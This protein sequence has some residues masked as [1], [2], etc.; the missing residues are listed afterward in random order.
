MVTAVTAVGLYFIILIRYFIVAGFF[1]WLLWVYKSP[2]FQNRRLNEQDPSPQVIKSE[3]KWSLLTAII[4]SIP[5]AIMIE[6]WKLGGTKIYVE[7]SEYGILYAIF[8]IPLYMFLHDTYFF[9]TH[10]L[11]HHPKLFKTFHQ[12]HHNSRSPTPWASFSFSLWEA[13]IEAL[14]IP[15]MAFFIPIHLGALAMVLTTMTVFGVT[16]HA[17][18][19][20]FPK[21]WMRGIWGNAMITA[22]HHNLHHRNYNVNYGLYFRFWDKLLGSDKMPEIV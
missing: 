20:I 16:N 5:G 15:V 19:E 4:F 18:Y 7:I 10:K 14:I 21:S 3:I 8:S 11:M 13:C 12:V 22:T 17:G 2:K 1:Y 6:A 9:W